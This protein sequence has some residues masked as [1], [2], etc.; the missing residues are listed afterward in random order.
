MSSPRNTASIRKVFNYC[1]S[2]ERL[3][4]KAGMRLERVGGRGDLVFLVGC[5]VT[6]DVNK[7]VNV[8]IRGK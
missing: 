8:Q 1:K 4:L 5:Y 2:P 7:C 3:I 6:G